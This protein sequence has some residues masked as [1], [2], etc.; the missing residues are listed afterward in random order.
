M[1]RTVHIWCESPVLLTRSQRDPRALPAVWPH[2]RLGQSPER[3]CAQ[4]RDKGLGAD[5]ARD[6]AFSLI[7]VL[8]ARLLLAGPLKRAPVVIKF[9]TEPR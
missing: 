5:P 2:P 9:T 1:R 6:S 7:N 8:L 4:K 3:G